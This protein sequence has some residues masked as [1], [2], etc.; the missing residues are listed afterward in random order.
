[1]DTVASQSQAGSSSKSAGTPETSDKTQTSKDAAQFSE[2]SSRSTP[3]AE[4]ASVMQNTVSAVKGYDD[5]KELSDSTKP[6]D[7]KL[8]QSQPAGDDKFSFSFEND[9]VNE[10][11]GAL[12]SWGSGDSV[13]PLEGKGVFAVDD[14]VQQKQAAVTEVGQKINSNLLKAAEV[15]GADI[16]HLIEKNSGIFTTNADGEIAL[17]PVIVKDTVRVDDNALLDED[18]LDRM[19]ARIQLNDRANAY[20]ELYNATG[21]EQ[22]V[23]QTQITT[24][25]GAIGSMALVGN[26]LAK[27]ANPE[28]YKLSL[29]Q[30][31]LDILQGT[32]DLARQFVGES[33]YN[34]D[35]NRLQDADH[36]V[37][38]SKGMGEH[39]PGNVQFVDYE[40]HN[41]PKLAKEIY[42]S[43]GTINS[44][45]NGARI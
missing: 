8:S 1:M 39:F 24:Y 45:T 30:F 11:S 33:V 40:W 5:N 34:L 44:F 23:L 17:N 20:L 7:D 14:A 29:D 12:G 28:K 37:W 19:Q 4:A 26:M 6:N 36:A 22:L 42:N 27:D 18:V 38:A 25:T 2:A 9:T 35:R 16:N 15:S 31:S 21:E 13:T 43:Q 32:H 41:D 3:V 10:N